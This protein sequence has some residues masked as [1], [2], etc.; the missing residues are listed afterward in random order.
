[1]RL[2]LVVNGSTCGSRQATLFLKIKTGLEFK[3]NT[4]GNSSPIFIL[5]HLTIIV[6]TIGEYAAAEIIANISS[7]RAWFARF[8]ARFSNHSNYIR[9]NMPNNRNNNVFIVQAA[10]NYEQ[11][12][13]NLIANLQPLTQFQKMMDLIKRISFLAGFFFLMV[14]IFLIF[15]EFNYIILLIVTMGGKLFLLCTPVYWVLVVDEVYDFTKRRANPLLTSVH[16]YFSRQRRV[17]PIRG[18]VD[19]RPRYALP[20]PGSSTRVLRVADEGTKDVLPFADPSTQVLRVAVERPIDV[21]PFARPST[22]VLGVPGAG[23][24]DVLPTARSSTRVLRVA[25]KGPK[26]VL[27][28]ARPSTRVLRVA[29]EGSRNV[30]ST[31]VS[32]TGIL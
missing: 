25:D 14:L 12:G 23:P 24:R 29:E 5:A 1:M 28:F 19:E 31:T 9:E 30:L 13:Q 20:V 26:D 27:S 18:G 8:R 10:E 16:H 2:S 15:L 22:R 21:L 17:A 7:Y 3:E 4:L 11:R 6:F 32:S